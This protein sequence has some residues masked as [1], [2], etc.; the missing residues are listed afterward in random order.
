M[1][2]HYS[3]ACSYNGTYLEKR[4]TEQ[5]TIPEG[6]QQFHARGGGG[7]GG[8]GEAQPETPHFTEN[9]HGLFKENPKISL[10]LLE[11]T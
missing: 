2:F 11:N 10:L 6:I 3:N 7:R 9:C 8:R 4:L 5:S 1:K